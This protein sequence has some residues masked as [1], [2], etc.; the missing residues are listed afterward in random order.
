M[1]GAGGLPRRCYARRVTC[2]SSAASYGTSAVAT[3]A[4]AVA[5]CCRCTTAGAWWRRSSRPIWSS[6]STLRCWLPAH[7]ASDGC[8]ATTRRP[9]TT[10]LPAH[11]Q[12]DHVATLVGVAVLADHLVPFGLQAQRRPA[13]QLVAQ[14]GLGIEGVFDGIDQRRAHLALGVQLEVLAVQVT[15]V[16]PLGGDGIEVLAAAVGE[17]VVVAVEQA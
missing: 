4:G 11:A 17:Y 16:V 2:C 8:W 13:V 10:E 7:R 5:T 1:H 12:A 9:N 3:A 14:A 15:L 6:A